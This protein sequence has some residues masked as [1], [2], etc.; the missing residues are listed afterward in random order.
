MALAAPLPTGAVT[1]AFTD[2]E[3]STVRWE[4]NRD[5]MQGAVRRHDT[6]LHDATSKHGGR[7]FKTTGGVHAKRVA[8]RGQGHPMHVVLVPL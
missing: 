7:V 8:F 6:I 4:S 5:A 3:G 2:I 1:F